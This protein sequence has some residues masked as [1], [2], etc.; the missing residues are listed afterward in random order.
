MKIN[1]VSNSRVEYIY[2]YINSLPNTGGN[3]MTNIYQKGSLDH[4]R[5]ASAQIVPEVSEY[6]QVEPRVGIAEHIDCIL[7]KMC[8]FICS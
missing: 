3:K 6:D 1:P 7:W 4:A 8:L 5:K 2:D